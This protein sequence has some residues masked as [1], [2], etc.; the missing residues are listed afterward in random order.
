[1]IRRAGLNVTPGRVAVL[2][3]LAAHPHID[4]AAVCR[5]VTAVLPTTS[6]QSVYNNLNDLTKAG[7]VHCIKPAGFAALYEVR[8]G[9]NHHHLI[10]TSCYAVVDV[11]CV[12]GS[13]PCLT[14]ADDHGFV[15]DRAEV[16]FWGL[17]PAC[18]AAYTKNHG[19][20]Q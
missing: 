14:P 19:V 1:M 18:Q 4:A 17:C 3:V 9:D 11:H 20:I 5:H 6:L 10:C 8:V 16:V 15:V 12:V 7:L 13:P 2:D